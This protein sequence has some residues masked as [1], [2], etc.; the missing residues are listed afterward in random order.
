MP[1]LHITVYVELDGNAL[2]PVSCQLL[3]E[4]FLLCVGREARVTAL[5]LGTPSDA[6]RAA[7]CS[8]PLER[9]LHYP[10]QGPFRSDLFCRLFLG[11]HP[12][13]KPGHRPHRLYPPGPCSGLPHRR[14]AA[15]RCHCRLHRTV[16][17]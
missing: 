11:G 3:D 7:L 8:W 12:A 2:A 6:T 17:L 10:V 9:I 5:V 4:A 13:V 1:D 15:H 16:P 14:N